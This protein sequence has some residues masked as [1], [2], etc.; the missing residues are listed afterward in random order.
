MDARAATAPHADPAAARR[1]GADAFERLTEP[2]RAELQAHCY[3][4]LGSAADAEDALQETLLRAWRGLPRFE[5]RSSLRSWL[6]R[7]ATNVCLKMIE[8]RPKRV[9]PIDY[10]AASDPHDAPQEP[11][12]ERVWLEPYPDETLET[13]DASGLPEVRYEQRESVELAFIA[14]LQHLPGR[15]RAVLLLRDVLGFAP[16]EIAAALDTTPAAI[17]SIL[18]RAHQA[19]EERLPAR[20]QQATL[21]TIGDPRLRELVQRYVRAWED[22][23]VAAIIE[24]LADDATFS[25]PPRPSWYRGRAAVGAFLAALPLS[26]RWRWRRVPIRA[27]GQ[28][29][30][31]AYLMDAAGRGHARAI[32]VLAVDTNARISDITSFHTPEAFARFGLP[33]ELLP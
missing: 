11:V 16:A 7:I 29:S 23:D 13:E 15:Q 6:Y 24:M 8:Q 12:V 14:A 26:G 1:R 9:V 28:P 17:Y 3:R 4:M 25:M 22:G 2:Y 32:E 27:N 33:E 19:A 5:G 30:F 31:G 21:R 18:Q 20:S 10:G